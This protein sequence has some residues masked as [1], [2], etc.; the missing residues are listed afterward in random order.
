MSDSLI[1]EECLRIPDAVLGWVAPVIVE[2]SPI[3]ESVP[4][5][6]T[7]LRRKESSTNQISKVLEIG[8]H[9][10][11][12]EIIDNFSERFGFLQH[13]LVK[14][15]LMC[16]GIEHRHEGDDILID[17]NWECLIHGLDLNIEKGKIIQNDDA[18]KSIGKRLDEISKATE[19]VTIENERRQKLEEEKR[20]ARI[21]AET[22]ARQKGENISATE[23][24]GQE[25][26]G[27]GHQAGPAELQQGRRRGGGG[28]GCRLR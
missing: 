3:I 9:V 4:S 2:S 19:I 28:G 13:G 26:A 20:T 16:L 7:N 5:N 8:K 27:A 6:Q 15:A 14:S 1:E 18:M 11:E 17:E 23:Q 22:S 24:A 25:A 10:I 21:Q 12:E